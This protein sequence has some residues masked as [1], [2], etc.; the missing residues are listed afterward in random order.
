MKMLRIIFSV[1]LSLL[2][3]FALLVQPAVHPAAASADPAPIAYVLPDDASGDE[4]HLISPDGTNDHMIWNTGKSRPESVL[5][6]GQLAWKPDASELAF[7]SNFQDGCS[8][9]SGDIYAI[10]GDGSGFRR[11]TAPPACGYNP[12][13]PTGA[14]ELNVFNPGDYGTYQVYIEGAQGP[15]SVTLGYGESTIVVFDNVMD[16]GDGIPQW[17]AGFYGYDRYSDVGDHVDVIAGK[18]VQATLSLFPMDR[19]WTSPVY[20][21]SDGK[22]VDIAYVQNPRTIFYK[23]SED[24]FPGDVGLEFLASGTWLGMSPQR[25]Q[26]VKGTN[27]LLYESY[28]TDVWPFQYEYY[29]VNQGANNPGTMEMATPVSLGLA[30]LPDGSGFLYSAQ[31]TVYDEWGVPT[32]FGNIFE[33]N[34]NTHQSTQLTQFTSGFTHEISVSPD[35]NRVVFEYQATGDWTDDLIS[36]DLYTMNRDGSNV[37]FLVKDGHSPAWS[38]SALPPAPIPTPTPDSTNYRVYIPDVIR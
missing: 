29:L 1:P 32:R 7:W 22:T 10:R 6:V 30:V 31:Q 26:W 33:F 37:S 18:T 23:P 20:L 35:G 21:S 13:L 2:P 5:G 16:Y 36:I 19:Y 25:L 3:I 17:A 8:V 15:K 4:I 38:P 28:N 11:V 9:Y 14:V 34:F 12:G 24:T 27:Q